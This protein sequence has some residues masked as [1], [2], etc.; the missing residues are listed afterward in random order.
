MGIFWLAC[1]Y[2]ACQS[3][4]KSIK[5]FLPDIQTNGFYHGYSV[6]FGIEINSLVS[7][8]AVFYKYLKQPEM[9]YSLPIY[10]FS[11]N[12]SLKN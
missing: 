12:Y 8:K 7:L 11:F 6:G 5:E 1:R 2:I 4:N 3:S 10:Q 9:D